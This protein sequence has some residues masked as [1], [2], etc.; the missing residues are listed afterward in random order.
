M[1]ANGLEAVGDAP[2]ISKLRITR[3]P[4]STAIEQPLPA[5]GGPD[6]LLFAA[7]PISSETLGEICLPSGCS[8]DG[9]CVVTA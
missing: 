2:P 4:Q 5:G 7:V 9:M 6:P 8:P 3:G 1:L